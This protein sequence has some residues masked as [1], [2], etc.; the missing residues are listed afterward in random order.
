MIF[1]IGEGRYSSKGAGYQKN[2]M[3][4]NKP[5]TE[6]EYESARVL[7]RDKA[8]KLPV[9]TWIDIKDIDEPTTTQKQL[10]GYLKTLSYKDAWAILWPT[11]SIEDQKFFSTL[12]NFDADIFERITG[13]KYEVN[14]VEEMTME[15]VCKALGK[16]IK[17][18]K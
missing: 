10:G 4:F 6:N 14:D 9:A 1:C 13:I 15:E 17:I 16:T 8:F 7:F 3:M 5:V 2:L 18:K 11:L 12:T